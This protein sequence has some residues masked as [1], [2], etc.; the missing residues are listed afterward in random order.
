M[1][2]WLDF[3]A[4]RNFVARDDLGRSQVNLDARR[5]GVIIA[6][7]LRKCVLT[8]SQRIRVRRIAENQNLTVARNWGIQLPT[9]TFLRDGFLFI[10]IMHDKY[11][12]E[13]M[14]RNKLK[15][16]NRMA[17]ANSFG[18]HTREQWLAMK[19]EFGGRCV[20][21]GSTDRV[22]CGHIIPVRFEGCSSNGMEN[23]QPTCIRCNIS[24]KHFR[25]DFRESRRLFGF[26]DERAVEH[27]LKKGQ[28]ELKELSVTDEKAIRNG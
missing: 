14:L 2:H 6:C 7:K 28:V 26:N 24:E 27:A 17:K 22:E 5:G 1:T 10:K 9:L 19:A 4:L 16:S 15:R 18:R 13:M 3:P 11:K 20:V 25:I 8:L 23:I 12:A 21:C